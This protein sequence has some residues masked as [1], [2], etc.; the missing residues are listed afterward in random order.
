MLKIA[1]LSGSRPW[2]SNWIYRLLR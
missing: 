1:L 2:R